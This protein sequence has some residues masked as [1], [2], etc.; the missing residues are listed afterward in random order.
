ML[1]TGVLAVVVVVA[2]LAIAPATSPVTLSAVHSDSM[3]PA[4]D[5]GD[6][7]LL[8][9]AGDVDS[10]DIVTFRSPRREAYVTHRV[11]RE[12]PDGFVTRGDD[13][14]ST[15]QA[16][17]LPPVQRDRIVGQ[18]LTVGG[19]PLVVPNLGTA[20]GFVRTNRLLALAAAAVVLLGRYALARASTVRRQDVFRVRDLVVPALLGLALV[21]AVFVVGGA[22]H[23][24]ISYPVEET[25]TPDSAVLRAGDEVTRNHRVYV[26]TPRYSRMF[27][28]VDGMTAVDRNVSRGSG[29]VMQPAT[30]NLTTRLTPTEP[31]TLHGEISVYAYPPL[32]PRSVLGTLHAVH[33]FLAAV[34]SSFTLYGTI[35]VGY[36]LLADG[37]VPLR[38][39]R[40]RP[41]RRFLEP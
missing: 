19:G 34:V 7:F 2:L 25:A 29:V 3:E 39:P 31:G 26:S 9:P 21:S 17:G 11:V 37:S 32:L 20:I 1:R 4:I 15:D 6:G 30:L 38:A 28:D 18:V 10:G 16:G 41:L 13:N 35:G 23:T 33:P 14:P 5:E 27:V 36:V 12:T 24:A 8:V 22:S 40:Y